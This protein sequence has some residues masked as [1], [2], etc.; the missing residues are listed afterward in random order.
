MQKERISKFL[1]ASLA[2]LIGYYC[3][4]VFL[5]KKKRKGKRQGSVEMKE[6][7]TRVVAKK[8][9]WFPSKEELDLIWKPERAPLDLTSRGK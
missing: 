5:A 2:S 6:K 1:L 9:C 3:I 7:K 8:G 4:R